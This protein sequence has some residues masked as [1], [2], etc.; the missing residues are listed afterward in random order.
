MF[1]AL[2]D[3]LRGAQEVGERLRPCAWPGPPGPLCDLPQHDRTFLVITINS[4]PLIEKHVAAAKSLQ[5]CPTLCDPRDGSAAGSPVPGILQARTL[6]RRAPAERLLWPG[7][8]S[9]SASQLLAFSPGK[10]QAAGVWET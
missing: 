10:E 5:S 3:E 4:I 2:R 8:A 7:R 9:P 1:D 6:E